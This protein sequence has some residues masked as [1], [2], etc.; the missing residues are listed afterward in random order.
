MSETIKSVDKIKMKIKRK[1]KDILDRDLQFDFNNEELL[2]K[3]LMRLTSQDRN[4]VV[5]MLKKFQYYTDS[6]RL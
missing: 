4:Y 1:Y 3:N 6:N 2:I 5:F